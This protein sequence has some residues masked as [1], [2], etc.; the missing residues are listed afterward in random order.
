MPK[1]DASHRADAS[2]ARQQQLK[3]L[4]QSVD[5]TSPAFFRFENNLTD[6]QKSQLGGVLNLSNTSGQRSVSQ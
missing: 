4:A 3:A 1:I 6:A 2:E 5:A